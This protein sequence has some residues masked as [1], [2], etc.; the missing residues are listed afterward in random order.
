LKV[1]ALEKKITFSISDMHC[2][3]C[4]LRLQ[5]LEDEIPGI[6]QV[7]ASYR[8]QRMEVRYDDSRISE[9]AILDAVRK[10]G[11]TPVVC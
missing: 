1:N 4:S 9:A 5:A 11:Y 7:D 8:K 2:S 10:T 6:L 3:S